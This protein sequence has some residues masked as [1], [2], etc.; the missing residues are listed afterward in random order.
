MLE[1]AN[2]FTWK[3]CVSPRDSVPSGPISMNTAAI[4][5]KASRAA[6]SPPVSTSTTT[7]RK[8]RKR[9]ASGSWVACSM[10]S[11]TR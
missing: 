9:L 2:G 5:S 10:G 7:G 3:E 6:F 8:L 4:S 1:P 11:F